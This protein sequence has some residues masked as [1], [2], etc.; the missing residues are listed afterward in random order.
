MVA[1]LHVKIQESEDEDDGD[2]E[3]RKEVVI[4]VALE[5]GG[6]ECDDGLSEHEHDEGG[7]A[8][9]DVVDVHGNQHAESHAWGGR[10]NGQTINQI[11]HAFNTKIR[12]N[13]KWNRKW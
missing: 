4:L 6:E 1:R 5:G 13:T 2:S 11:K 8:R 9:G 10:G 12:L 3:D 7:G